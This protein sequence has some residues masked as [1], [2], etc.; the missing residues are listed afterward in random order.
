MSYEEVFDGALKKLLAK[1]QSEVYRFLDENSLRSAL[2]F[3]CLDLIDEKGLKRL[4]E[5]NAPIPGYKLEG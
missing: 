4:L 5:P 1:Y 2:F 3:E